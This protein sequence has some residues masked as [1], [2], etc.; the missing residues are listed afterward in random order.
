V[1]LSSNHPWHPNRRR[2]DLAQLFQ[3]VGTTLAAREPSTQV[4][5]SQQ[6]LTTRSSLDPGGSCSLAATDC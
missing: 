4:T 1:G 2:R 5:D 6:F 3:H